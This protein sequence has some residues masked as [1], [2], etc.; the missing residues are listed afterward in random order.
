MAI[1]LHGTDRDRLA[2][3]FNDLAEGGSIL[4][5][6]AR[7]PWDAEVGWL[8]DRFGITWTVNIEKA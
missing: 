4:V 6:L 3:A 7:Q 1:A 5:P 2:G 8:R